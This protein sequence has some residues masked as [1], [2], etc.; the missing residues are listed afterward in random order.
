VSGP[1]TIQISNE[2]FH[3]GSQSV[4][5]VG[6]GNSTMF[7]N[8]SVFPLP[9]G[10]V[11]FRVWM[12]FENADWSGHIAFVAAGP[13]E[14]SQEVRFGGQQGYYHA[15]LA[16][17]S[18]GLSPNPWAQPSCE[19]C[20]AP[21]A[22]EWVCLRGMFDFANNKAQLYVGDALAVDAKTKDDWHTGNGILP[23]NP[24]KIGFGWALYGGVQNTVYYDDLAIGYEPIPCE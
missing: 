18:D 7:N 6:T 8:T 16:G 17:D 24:T 21:V 20:V 9:T 15:N 19:L 23:S 10:V 22:N 4:K 14:E 11:H 3:S 2:Q 1:G 13:G 5:V 12:R